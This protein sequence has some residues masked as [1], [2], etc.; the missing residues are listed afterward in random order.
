MNANDLIA[1]GIYA[2]A[3]LG[4]VRLVFGVVRAWRERRAFEFFSRLI[5][6]VLQSAMLWL[7][8][9]TILNPD[10]GTTVAGLFATAFLL[11]IV[12]LFLGMI[13]HFE[14]ANS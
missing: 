7:F 6:L 3:W 8:S 5:G 10:G 11:W 12:P 9:Y 1:M 2:L 14:G 4:A 13:E